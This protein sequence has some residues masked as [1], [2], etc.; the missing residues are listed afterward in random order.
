M[1]EAFFAPNPSAGLV[2]CGSTA[3]ALLGTGLG[4]AQ[5][6]R[7]HALIET[8]QSHPPPSPLATHA[9]DILYVFYLQ[10]HF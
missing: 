2:P 4:T 1:G 3:T 6:A 7:P 10:C 9:N 8:L 5:R